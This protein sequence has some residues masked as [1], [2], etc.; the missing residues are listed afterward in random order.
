M[1]SPSRRCGDLAGDGLRG[2]GVDIGNR[3]IGALGGEDKRRGAAHA[4][5]GAGDENGQAFDRAAELFEIRHDKIPTMKAGRVGRIDKAGT[6][7]QTGQTKP[8]EVQS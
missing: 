2:L 4:A 6:D 3:H 1:P 5:G 7:P 8:S